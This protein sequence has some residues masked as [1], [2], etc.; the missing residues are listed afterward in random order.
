MAMSVRGF[1]SSV[2]VLA[3]MLASVPALAV[4]TQPNGDAIPILPS[5]GEYGVVTSRGFA[6]SA[7]ELNGLF[8]ARGEML[9]YKA[10]AKTT[11][12]AFSPTCGF[13][14]ELVLRGG[15]ALAALGWYNVNDPKQPPP[16]YPLVP[17]SILTAISNTQDNPATPT[18][19]ECVVAATAAGA[20]C[21]GG[22][23]DFCPLAAP[24][25]TQP[26]QHCWSD[27]T[28]SSGDIKSNPNYLGGLVGFA[29]YMNDHTTQTKYSE[30]KLNVLCTAPGCTATDHWVTALIWQSTATPEGFYIGFEDLGMDKTDWHKLPQGDTSTTGMCDG[31]FNDF[32][33]FVSGVNCEGGNKP[34][35][36]GLMGACA[37]GH[38]DCAAAGETPACRPAVQ[39]SAEICDNVDNDC[40][41]V[42]DNGDGLCP[43]ASKPIC[44]QGNCVGNCSR[45]EFP[46]PDGTSCDASGHCVDPSCAAVTCDPGTACRNGK[47][48]DPCSGAVC[49]VGS[50]CELG[51]CVNPC[52][53]V[54]CPSD[55]VCNKGLCVADCG[56]GG[57]DAGFACG[58]DGKC[59]E[60][61]CAAVTCAADKICQMGNCV[62]PCVGVI[63][64]GGGTCTA[65]VCS[66]PT[67]GH[68]LAAPP[69]AGGQEPGFYFG[70]GG[71]GTG[72]NASGA[73]TSTGTRGALP[74]PKSGCGCRL[75]DSSTGGASLGWLSA[76]LGLGLAGWARRRSVRRAA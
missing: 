18:V 33:Y 14:G 11:P 12:G 27:A 69:D 73:A 70:N 28:F 74:T 39:K 64:P 75:A 29:L 22:D 48:V 72:N 36:T 2:G 42:V 67:S 32:V 8:A 50:Q 62:D 34:C 44:F 59:I 47:C 71:S 54:T 51:T 35:D 53:G 60:T 1:V 31:D 40:D 46:C 21:G 25:L 45:G 56:C 26:T 61:A 10:D 15:A 63:C 43:D 49:P 7:V 6:R 52:A 76:A 30:A 57:C 55:R 65:G 19:N 9:D 4:V 23:H 13:S 58:K 3:M 24:S 37:V 66:A 20:L 38:T 41:G 68:S 5:E 16:V 17:L